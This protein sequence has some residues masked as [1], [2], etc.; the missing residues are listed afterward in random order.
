LPALL[1]RLTDSGYRFP[2][3]ALPLPGDAASIGFQ[4]ER[5][6]HCHIIGSKYQTRVHTTFFLN[7]ESCCR[8]KI[9]FT[10]LKIYEH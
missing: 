9:L 5:H 2:T 3:P 7:R 4:I 8:G 1:G 10:L 6:G